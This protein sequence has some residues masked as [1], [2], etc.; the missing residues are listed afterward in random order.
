MKLR[1]MT[2]KHATYTQ[3]GN[4]PL[5]VSRVGFGCWPI[6]GVSSLNV[7]EADSIRTVQA[8][9]DAGINFFDTAFGYGYQGEADRVLAKA[10]QGRR[11]DVVLASKVGMHFDANRNRV[12][13]GRPETLVQQT[14]ELLSRLQV[15]S[16]DI[17]YLHLPDPAVPLEESAGAIADILRRGMAR[18]AGVSNVTSEQLARFHQECPVIVVQPPF[19]MLQPESVIELRPFCHRQNISIAAYWVLMKGLLAGKLRRDHQFDPRDKRLTYEVFQGEA[20]ERSQ[21]LL[22][23]LSE[24]ALEKKSTVAQLVIA[25]T[26]AQPDVSVALCGAK[27]PEQI[28]ETA[29]SMS[30][31]VDGETLQR[32]DCIQ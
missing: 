30:I 31:E 22:D 24:I 32:I 7:T 18:Y 13:D 23:R 6:A 11:Q 27:R 15:D 20:W 17:L 8:A 10:L 14:A 12:I 4:S 29:A 1:L 21:R 2:S 28:R 26:L 3:L 9:L 5:R 16:V 25:W 19:N